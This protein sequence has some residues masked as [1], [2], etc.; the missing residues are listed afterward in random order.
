M[1]L[2]RTGKNNNYQ[3]VVARKPREYYT[4][5]ALY[6]IE[7]LSNALT[8]PGLYHPRFG[9]LSS[10][11]A[12]SMKGFVTSQN[13][14][15]QDDNGVIIHLTVT[16]R[17]YAHCK[18]CI[19]RIINQGCQSE[20]SSNISVQEC[21]PH[22]DAS[23]LQQLIDRYPH[24]TVTV[25]FYGGEP[26]LAPERMEEV[27]ERLHIVYDSSR[28]RFLV[29]TN[30]ELLVDAG[31]RYPRLLD[32][33]W[34]Y[35]VSIDGDKE[36]HNRVRPGTDL[37]KI[38]HNLQYL[39]DT[40]SRNVLLW[41]TLREEQSLLNCFLQFQ[42][43]YHHGL[44]HYMFWHWAET[45]EPFENFP[46]FA[47]KYGRDL[48]QVMEIY[49]K[50]LFNGRL[51]PIAHVNDLLIYILT[52]KVRGH[53]ACAV[54]LASNYDIVDG[55]VHACA[56]L[57]PDVAMLGGLDSRGTL[58]LKETGLVSLLTYKGALGCNK[59]GVHAYCGGRC[60]VQA[61]VGIPQRTL[62]YCQLMRL[63]VGI[64]KERMNEII[65]ALD[66]YRISP[67]VIYDHSAFIAGFTDVVP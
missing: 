4:E 47:E 1:R 52:G 20:R 21:D 6:D 56:D 22:R 62:Q 2:Q 30:G 35:S 29:Y 43:L 61:L 16:G 10:P 3:L 53:T 7:S 44:V 17:C 45:S 26:F 42:D 40:G 37:S 41:S 25:C 18:G 31:K 60:P 59:C 8:L 49:V 48:E 57:P 33:L 23:I 67:Q 28:V 5:F 39:R 50:E 19:N 63:H 51:L 12:I 13:S 66:K 58:R 54:E 38:M 64:V 11:A 46:L 9:D 15:M 55:R 65:R 24:S 34:L 14:P 27:I 32:M 36:Q